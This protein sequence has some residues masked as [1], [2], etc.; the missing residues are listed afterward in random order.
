MDG[1]ACSPRFAVSFD[2]SVVR[3][4]GGR[5]KKHIPVRSGACVRNGGTCL[6]KNARI[7]DD[8]LRLAENRGCGRVRTNI[9]SIGHSD[10]PQRV[11]SARR[12]LRGLRGRAESIRHI[13]SFRW[14]LAKRRLAGS[15][16]RESIGATRR[17][18]IDCFSYRLVGSR[19][20]GHTAEGGRQTFRHPFR[21]N[22]ICR[23]PDFD[24]ADRAAR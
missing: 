22:A 18:R 14:H 9:D 2:R 21:H 23:T 24:S 1:P 19:G 17:R 10:R 15:F 8:G 11:G 5:F 7:H 3:W 4:V 6:G 20:R 13:R 16:N 12:R